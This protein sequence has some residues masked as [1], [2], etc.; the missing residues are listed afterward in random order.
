MV[1]HSGVKCYIKKKLLN[2]LSFI[3]VLGTYC[4]QLVRTRTYVCA[5][6][7]TYYIGIYVLPN[8][9]AR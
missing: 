2:L 5:S 4:C 6:V 1:Y 7:G 9:I 3:D 8:Y